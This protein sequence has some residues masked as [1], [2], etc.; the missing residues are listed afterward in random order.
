MT[1]RVLV[2]LPGAALW[3]RCARGNFGPVDQVSLVVGIEGACLFRE[4][5]T[6]HRSDG[7]TERAAIVW[8]FEA[9]QLLAHFARWTLERAE[10]WRPPEERI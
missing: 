9:E 3:Y 8:T 4:P 1:G 7:T 2:S 6:V 5:A 10:E